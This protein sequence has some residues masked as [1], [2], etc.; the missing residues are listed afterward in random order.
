MSR[1]AARPQSPARSP[2]TASRDRVA[3]DRQQRRQAQQA[4]R[5]HADRSQDLQEADAAAGVGEREKGREHPGHPLAGGGSGRRG[6]RAGRP[7]HPLAG[8][9]SGSRDRV[10]QASPG[11]DAPGYYMSPLRG[12]PTS[13]VQFGTA[14][15]PSPTDNFGTARRPSPTNACPLTSHATSLPSRWTGGQ[16]IDSRRSQAFW[17]PTGARVPLLAISVTRSCPCWR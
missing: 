1:S 15:R 4:D 17:A 6:E 14:R 9:G 16:N 3:S 13:N 2:L 7:G 10:W 11:A 8:G 12:W 5:E